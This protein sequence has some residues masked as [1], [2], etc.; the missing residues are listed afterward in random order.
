M[1]LLLPLSTS[2]STSNANANENAIPLAIPLI[3]NLLGAACWMLAACCPHVEE[4]S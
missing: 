1:L 3:M 4:Q 2:T